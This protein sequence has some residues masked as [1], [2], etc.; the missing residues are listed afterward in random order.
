MI[1]ATTTAHSTNGTTAMPITEAARINETG[2]VRS[3]TS[4]PTR[5]VV[6]GLA[7]TASAHVRTLPRKSSARAIEA[8]N[9]KPTMAHT[10]DSRGTIGRPRSRPSVS[11]GTMACSRSAIPFAPMAMCSPPGTKL[12]GAS[13]PPPM[14]TRSRLT[15]APGWTSTFP[16]TAIS[17][18]LMVARRA[19]SNG[20]KDHNEIAAH[21]ALDRGVAEHRHDVM[22]RLALS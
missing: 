21:R 20:T 12:G 8:R 2:P 22:R 13:S 5:N 14:T 3:K 18:P 15:V 19:H 17:E 6:K 7:A 4:R 10:H 9:V 11:H 16:P 1:H